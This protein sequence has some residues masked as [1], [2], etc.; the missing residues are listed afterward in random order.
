VE[1]L[2]GLLLGHAV[3]RHEDLED[4]VGVVDDELV[5][6]PGDDPDDG[7]VEAVGAEEGLLDLLGVFVNEL[8][9]RQCQAL[10][11]PQETPPQGVLSRSPSRAED[12][13]VLKVRRLPYEEWDR[14]RVIE[15]FATDGL[16]QPAGWVILVVER[17]GQIVGT[18]S[19]FT[20]VHWDCWWIAPEHR[21]QTSVLRALL[22][23]AREVFA[24]AGV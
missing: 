17:D 20:A 23:G 11:G 14:L 3:A 6:A 8:P 5:A 13:G 9:G 22:L 12:V 18:C 19:L 7:D 1:E 16:P 15:P 2:P 24:E 10:H 21:R 4:E